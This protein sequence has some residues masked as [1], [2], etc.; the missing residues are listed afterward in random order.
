MSSLRSREGIPQA[1]EKVHV[2]T[3]VGLGV[4]RENTHIS[5][6]LD[7]M[8]TGGE[9]I[10]G[11]SHLVMKSSQTLLIQVSVAVV[12][13]HG[14]PGSWQEACGMLGSEVTFFHNQVLCQLA[15]CLDTV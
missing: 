8:V 6:I 3:P 1:L 13:I 12:A 11:G 7:A 15:V 10:W 5:C 9:S 2:G 4:R 14:S